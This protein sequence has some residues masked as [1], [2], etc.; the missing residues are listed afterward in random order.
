MVHRYN[1]RGKVDDRFEGKGKPI[2][3]ITIIV[4]IHICIILLPQKV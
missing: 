1:G 2:V 3:S 4:N